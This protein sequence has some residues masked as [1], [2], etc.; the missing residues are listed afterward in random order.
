M[1]EEIDKLREIESQGSF[2]KI[3]K[4]ES[5]LRHILEG[6]LTDSEIDDLIKR[7]ED[8]GLSEKV[9]S[10][11]SVF[12]EENGSNPVLAYAESY[13]KAIED[14]EKAK[15]AAKDIDRLELAISSLEKTSEGRDF[16]S[17]M[18]QFQNIISGESIESLR[19]QQKIL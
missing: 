10:D 8:E 3:E 13:V 7:I 17:Y 18:T 11:L 6:K 16:S 14:F 1:E 12:E 9:L 15:G 4:E 5:S 2:E 19:E